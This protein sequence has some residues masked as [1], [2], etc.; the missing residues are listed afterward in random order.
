VEGKGNIHVWELFLGVEVRRIRDDPPSALIGMGVPDVMGDAVHV[1]GVHL[2][3]KVY[4]L[5]RRLRGH[6][7]DDD[8]A[9][10]VSGREH[11]SSV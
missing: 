4:V 3:E 11:A 5:I 2:L 8:L 7:V 6:V 10:F 9:L 1:L